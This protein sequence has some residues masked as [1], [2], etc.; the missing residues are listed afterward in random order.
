MRIEEKTVNTIRIIAAEAVQKANSGHPGLP[1]GAAA[2]GYGLWGHVMIHNPQDPK[3]INRDRF[4]LSAGHGSMLIYTLL[5]LFE[6]GLELEDLKQFRQLGSLTPGHPEYGHTVGVETTTGPLGQGIA[7]GVG[8]A[9][10]EKYLAA[11][12]N[13]TDFAI[14]DHYTYV[15][16]GDGCMMEGI[17]SE[18]A[19]LAGTLKL[20]KLVVIYD[21]NQITIEGKTDVAFTEDVGKRYEAYGWRVIEVEDGNNYEPVVEALME[22]KKTRD[23]PT[24]VIAKT[25]IGYGCEAKQGTP[26]VHGEPLGQANLELTKEAL[27]F[28]K[29]TSFVIDEDV[30]EHLKSLN[31]GK[32]ENYKEWMALVHQYKEVYPDL[33]DQ[34]E[35]WIENNFQLDTELFNTISFDKPMATRSISG[36]ILNKIL[37][38]VPNIMGGSA[39]LAPSTKTEMKDKGFFS[40]DN[41]GASNLHFGVREHAM[42]AIVNGVTLHGGLRGFASTFLVFSDYMKGAMRLSALMELPAI[43][44]LTHDS[45]GV[46]EDG[47]THQPIE[48]LAALRSMPNMELWRPADGRETLAAWISAINNK[49]APSSIVLTR[50]NLPQYAESGKEALKGA[51]TLLD[52]KGVPEII[53]MA[54]GSEV[55]IAYEAVKALEGELKIRLVSVPSMEVFEKQSEDYKAKLLPLEVEKRIAIEAGTSFGWHKYVGLK[56]KVLAIDSFGAS[57]PAEEVYAH[58]GLTVEKLIEQ[59]K[60]L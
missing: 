51:Y 31:K 28:D 36:E 35:Y 20:D 45:I 18:A 25:I 7:N 6:Y 32:K 46:G 22:A 58:F 57:G 48:H 2:I 40:A 24:L 12:F 37:E 23:R 15:L 52:T 60:N 44:I 59:L 9:I 29:N 56:G 16:A 1:M 47:P 14:M 26:G 13:R 55:E 3:W 34:L 42:A 27:G 8:M 39:D 43:Y 19:S 5:H 50:Q 33:Y 38:Y 49:K 10:A 41:R 11:Q 53:L 54:T 17:S 21:S 30:Y 4:I